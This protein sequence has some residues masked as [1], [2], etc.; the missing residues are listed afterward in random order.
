[1][2]IDTINAQMESTF[3]ESLKKANRV[4]GFSFNVLQALRFLEELALGL[5]RSCTLH[6]YENRQHILLSVAEVPS[7]NIRYVRRQVGG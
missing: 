3:E 5:Y 4:L 1:V 2:R 6:P 7:M